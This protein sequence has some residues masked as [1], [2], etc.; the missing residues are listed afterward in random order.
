MERRRKGDPGAPI[1]ILAA[2]MFYRYIWK[3]RYAC[4]WRLT[5]CLSSAM[6]ASMNIFFSIKLKKLYSKKLL[7]IINRTLKNRRERPLELTPTKDLIRLRVYVKRNSAPIEKFV[8][9]TIETSGA[10][11]SSSRVVYSNQHISKIIPNNFA[12]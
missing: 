8:G 3:S 7:L 4:G 11:P 10:Y 5:I 2:P 1:L 9:D 6:S 12:S